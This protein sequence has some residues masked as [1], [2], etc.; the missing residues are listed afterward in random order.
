MEAERGLLISRADD[1][2]DGSLDVVLSHGFEHDPSHSA[3]AQ[4]FA[5]AV[6]ARDEILREDD[7]RRPSDTEATAADGEI[8]TLVAIPLYLRDR[9]HGVIVCANRAGG[10]EEVGDELLLA[11][12]DHAGAA[13]QHGRLEHELRDAHR[14]AV[15]VLTEA[16]AAQDPVLHLS[17]IHI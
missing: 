9:F 2:G 7:P 16:V 1:D 14:S 8:D 3:V 10:F 4:R 13:L 6:L 11:L 15:R 17:L 5:R 12:G